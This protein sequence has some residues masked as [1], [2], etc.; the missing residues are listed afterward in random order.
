MEE[1]GCFTDEPKMGI[2]WDAEQCAENPRKYEALTAINWNCAGHI[3]IESSTSA[4]CQKSSVETPK[5]MD[6][7]K[8][9]HCL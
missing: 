4:A 2:I 9:K 1:R 3:H 8:K 6:Q 5:A 7:K